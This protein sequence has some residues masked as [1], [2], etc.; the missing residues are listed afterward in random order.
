MSDSR[1]LKLHVTP[2]LAY[3]ADNF[4]LHAGVRDVYEQLMHA[5]SGPRFSFHIAFGAVRSGKTHLSL[6]LADSLV[7][8][9]RFPRVV[10]GAELAQILSDPSTSLLREDDIYIVDDIDSY[11]TSVGPGESGPCVRF[12]EAARVAGTGLFF[13]STTA[14]EDF[15]CDAHILSRLRAAAHLD[16][17]DPAEQDISRLIGIMSRQRG[18]A[19]SDRQQDFLRKRLPRSVADIEEYLDGLAHLTN[20]LGRAVPLP[21]PH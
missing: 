1:Q 11:F 3:N 10:D 14:L 19:L 12:I 9:G 2:R 16:I 18:I 21:T 17:R 15:P 20:T 8:K 5:L 4:L 13:L 7:R 6:K